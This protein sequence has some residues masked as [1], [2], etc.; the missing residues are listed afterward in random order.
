MNWHII[1]FIMKTTYPVEFCLAV[2]LFV[3]ILGSNIVKATMHETNTNKNEK[4][5]VTIVWNKCHFSQ[6]ITSG[7]DWS[8]WKLP[9]SELW[10]F[11][12]LRRVYIIGRNITLTIKGT[13][14]AIKIRG[15]VNLNFFFEKEYATYMISHITTIMRKIKAY[16]R[17][18][19]V[20]NPIPGI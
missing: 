15:N 4:I 3:V 10:Q 12:T 16:K 17:T 8:T 19:N 7:K 14:L 18:R 6:Q 9:S 5:N 2:R 20:L 13:I 1:L 11:T